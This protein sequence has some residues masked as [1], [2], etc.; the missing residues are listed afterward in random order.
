MPKAARLALTVIALVVSVVSLDRVRTV[1]TELSKQKKGPGA[2]DVYA[3]P[4]PA[5]VK[6][7]SLGYHDAVA[8]VLWASTLYQY[9]EH[10][11]RNQRFEYATQYLET[12]VELDPSFRPAYR[13]ASTLLTMQAVPPSRVELDR[14]RALLEQGTHELPHDADVWG[15]YAS[16]MM[17]EGAQYLDDHDKMQWRVVGARAAQRAVEL[18]FFMDTL[19]ISGAT[20]LERAG[21]RDLAIA[22]LERAYAVAPNDDTRQRIAAKLRRLQAQESLSRVERVHRYLMSRWRNEVSWTSES[23]YVLIGPQRDIAHCAGVAGE[24]PRCDPSWGAAA[25]ANARALP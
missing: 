9:G 1:L 19:S 6:A 8:S 12:I 24:D 22:Q 23:L 13:F 25:L 2:D 11:G 18:G 3:L 4:P 7:A 15:A 17:F 14:V 16:Y 5:Y 20:F 21:E 10:V